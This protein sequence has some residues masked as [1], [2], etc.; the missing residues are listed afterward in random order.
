[1]C[2]EKLLFVAS[3]LGSEFRQWNVFA[4]GDLETTK[5]NGN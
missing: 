4:A 1:M 5:H 2:A 3:Q